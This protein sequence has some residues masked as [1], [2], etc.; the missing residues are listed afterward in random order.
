MQ[1]RLSI[2]SALV[3]LVFAS[4]TAAQD[5]YKPTAEKHA[6]SLSDDMKKSMKSGDGNLRKFNQ[7]LFTYVNGLCAPDPF[8][9]CNCTFE[10]FAASCDFVIA[11]LGS[12]ACVPDN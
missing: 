6:Y 4:Q 11:C 12:G 7:L 5:E 1:I 10:G 2:I 3:A 8:V 9:P